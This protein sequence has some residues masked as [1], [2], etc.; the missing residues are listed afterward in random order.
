LKHETKNGGGN[1]LFKEL[2][3]IEKDYNKLLKKP[4]LIIKLDENDFE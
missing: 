3:G 4:V 1:K 2:A